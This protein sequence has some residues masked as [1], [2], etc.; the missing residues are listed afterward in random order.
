MTR[1]YAA[2]QKIICCY[3]VSHSFKLVYQRILDPTQHQL[4][5]NA[6]TTLTFPT[7]ATPRR[8]G[9][10]NTVLGF[11]RA[12]FEGLREGHAIAARYERL[13]RMRDSELARLGLRRSDIPQA[14]VAGVHGL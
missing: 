12:V 5:C 3:A 11:L 7:T 8:S 14:A 13:S 1:H 6:M 4:G 2:M 10:G 9:R